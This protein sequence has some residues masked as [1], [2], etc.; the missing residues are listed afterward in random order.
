M[1]APAERSPQ[2]HES[3]A[4]ASPRPKADDQFLRRI[5]FGLVTATLLTG[6]VA[7]GLTAQQLRPDLVE[8]ASLWGPA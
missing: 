7:A 8:I 1:T 3:T 2:S 6:A 5:L 4:S